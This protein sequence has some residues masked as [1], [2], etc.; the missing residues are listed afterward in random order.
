MIVLNT[1]RIVLE[2]YD[3]L[4]ALHCFDVPEDDLMELLGHNLTIDFN[5]QID[6]CHSAYTTYADSKAVEPYDFD[7]W[8]AGLY[9]AHDDILYM[10]R[11]SV[12]ANLYGIDY[13]KTISDNFIFKQYLKDY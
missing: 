6:I 2:L 12:D 9:Q 1:Y 8:L 13:Y 7:I 4:S 10:L 11:A 5:H 3:T